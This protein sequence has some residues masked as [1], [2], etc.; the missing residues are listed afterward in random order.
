MSR[1]E[2]RMAGAGGR[3]PGSGELLPNGDRVSVRE[4]NKA[5]EMDGGE[6]NVLEAPELHTSKGLKRSILCH[7]Y[8]T[9]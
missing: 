1:R 4:D 5:V 2:R 3:G 6:V 9:A 7:V 8:F